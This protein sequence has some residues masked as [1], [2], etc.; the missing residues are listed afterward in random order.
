MAY[1]EASA[2]GLPIVAMR[3]GG[4]EAVVRDGETG[5]LTPEGDS[6]AFA[7]ALRRM[8]DDA[9]LR[10]RLGECGRRFVTGER[11]LASAAGRLDALLADVAAARRRRA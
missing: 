8:I 1:L 3:S 7:G 10:D 11:S 5:L 4:V 2:R 9:P 6:A